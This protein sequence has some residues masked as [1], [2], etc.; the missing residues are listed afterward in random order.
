MSKLNHNTGDMNK[1][2]QWNIFSLD[3]LNIDN[4]V[5]DYNSSSSYYSYLGIDNIKDEPDTH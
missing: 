3:Y 1:N 4:M 2:Y 5:R